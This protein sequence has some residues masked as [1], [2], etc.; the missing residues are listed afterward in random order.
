MHIK[1]FS[2]TLEIKKKPKVDPR[3]ISVQKTV[4][5]QQP[6]G[7]FY[8]YMR[9]KALNLSV[10]SRKDYLLHILKRYCTDLKSLLRDFVLQSANYLLVD[11]WADTFRLD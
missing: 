5:K 4:K 3:G 8:I 2:F 9:H 11:N 6:G 10:N 7:V 1:E